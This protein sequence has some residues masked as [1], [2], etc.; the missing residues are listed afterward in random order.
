MTAGAHTFAVGDHVVPV[1]DHRPAC[2]IESGGGIVTDL[3]FSENY[4]IRVEDSQ[5]KGHLFRPTELALALQFDEELAATPTEPIPT[6]TRPVHPSATRVG[7]GILL[8]LAL[9]IITGVLAAPA[10]VQTIEIRSTVTHAAPPVCLHAVAAAEIEMAKRDERDTQAGY[11]RDAVLL[12]VEAE[13]EGNAD[14]ADKQHALA[15]AAALLRDEAELA[16]IGAEQS[17]TNHAAACLTWKVAQR[18]T[19][20]VA[21]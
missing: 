13:E 3:E 20:R 15:N 6:V 8:G 7:L 5:G 2:L 18:V 14:E 19:E 21:Q 11:A 4:P 12:M 16:R 10:D 17:F 1:G 9:G